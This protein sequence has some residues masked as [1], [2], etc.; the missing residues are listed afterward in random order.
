[1]IILTNEQLSKLESFFYWSM[2]YNCEADKSVE[3]IEVPY[4]TTCAINVG[5]TRA[6]CEGENT[7]RWA[8][9][10]AVIESRNYK[11][12]LGQKFRDI[13]GDFNMAVS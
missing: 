4:L 12:Y 8:M 10:T 11:K 5:Y 3:N 1:M 2:E 6:E 13:M 7:P 9:A